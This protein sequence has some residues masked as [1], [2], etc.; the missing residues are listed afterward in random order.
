MK[1]FLKV[2]IPILISFTN[3]LIFDSELIRMNI[4]IQGS[5]LSNNMKFYSM[6]LESN[7]SNNDLLVDSKIINSK[8]IHESPIILISTVINYI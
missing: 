3:C 2:L 1:G 5:T 4:V 8:T 7:P 6:D